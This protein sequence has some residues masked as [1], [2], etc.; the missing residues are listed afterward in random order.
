MTDLGAYKDKFSDSG[1]RILEHAMNESRRRD[2]NY[3]SVEHI[4]EALASE[5]PDLFD[6]TMKD[7]LVDPT[8]VKVALEQR[9]DG[10]PQHLGKGFKIAP[11]TTDIFKRSM[12]R[13]RA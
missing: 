10:V 11:E 7:L 13:A 12:D 8:M 3:V 5:E 9:L 1:K 4:L 2:Q 6:S